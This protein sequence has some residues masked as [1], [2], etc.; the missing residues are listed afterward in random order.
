ML[1]SSKDIV[2][3]NLPDALPASEPCYAFLA[4]PHSHTAYPR[5][6]ISEKIGRYM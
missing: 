5:R 6:E 1:N 3:E 4:W 2:I